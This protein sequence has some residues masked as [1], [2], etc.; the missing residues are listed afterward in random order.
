M[1]TINFFTHTKKISSRFITLLKCDHTSI[2]SHSFSNCTSVNNPSGIPLILFDGLESLE[3]AFEEDLEEDLDEWVLLS[4]LERV[5]EQTFVKKN[6]EVSP[7]GQTFQRIF[8][9]WRFVRSHT[10]QL[11]W[12]QSSKVVRTSRLLSEFVI[13]F[14]NPR[15]LNEVGYDLNL[16]CWNLNTNHMSAQVVMSSKQPSG[17]SAGSIHS[18]AN[19]LVDH[20]RIWTQREDIFCRIS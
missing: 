10:P 9:W 20:P 18:R 3:D 8:C 6:E 14:K 12:D 17:L 5:M 13:L 11:R 7:V 19:H 15:T 2:L 16:K 4:I 1:L